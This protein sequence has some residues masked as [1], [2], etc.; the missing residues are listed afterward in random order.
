MEQRDRLA[1]QM[2]Q[3]I[4]DEYAMVPLVEADKLFVKNDDTVGEWV[5]IKWQWMVLNYEYIT[6]PTP[7]GTFR[8]FEP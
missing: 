1:R 7:L 5:T 3:L 8:L 4:Y 2:T 6:Q